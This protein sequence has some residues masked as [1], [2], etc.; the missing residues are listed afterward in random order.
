MQI[1][2][3]RAALIAERDRLIDYLDARAEAACD[4][5]PQKELPL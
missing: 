5:N 3:A 4:P 2:G 1:N